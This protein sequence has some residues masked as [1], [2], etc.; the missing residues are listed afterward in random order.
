MSETGSFFDKSVVKTLDL[1]RAYDIRVTQVG[2]ASPASPCKYHLVPDLL[3]Y[4]T[5]VRHTGFCCLVHYRF[6]SVVGSTFYYW[7]KYFTAKWIFHSKSYIFYFWN[8]DK[9]EIQII[10]YFSRICISWMYEKRIYYQNKFSD[11]LDVGSNHCTTTNVVLF[12][13]SHKIKLFVFAKQV[14]L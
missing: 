6:K 2:S 13:S 1:Y 9:L 12:A 14:Y 8:K 4:L 5:S 10:V 7:E 11:T 3:Q